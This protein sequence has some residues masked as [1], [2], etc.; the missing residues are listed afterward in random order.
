MKNQFVIWLIGSMALFAGLMPCFIIVLRGKIVE[1]FFAVQTS[2]IVVVFSII[3]LTIS[4]DYMRYLDIG[5]VLS[6]IVIM[7]SIVFARFLERWI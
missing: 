5:L 7:S 1:R 6:I 3:V 2:Q 4:Y